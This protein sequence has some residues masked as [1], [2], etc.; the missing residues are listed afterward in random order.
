MDAES[1]EFDRF[2]ASP[3]GQ[4]AAASG[5][6]FDHIGGHWFGHADP[7]GSGRVSLQMAE[8]HPLQLFDIAD[9]NHDGVI[10][11]DEVRMAQAMRSLAGH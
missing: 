1:A 2:R 11:L 9:V 3:A 8:A 6:P 7:D 10:G 4:A 5:N